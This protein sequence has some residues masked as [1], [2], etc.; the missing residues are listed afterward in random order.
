MKK[1]KT[2]NII[3]SFLVWLII[4]TPF[5]VVAFHVTPEKDNDWFVNFMISTQTCISLIFASNIASKVY[6]WLEDH[7]NKKDNV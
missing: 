6:C 4:M 2:I 5:I 1:N 3:I 7:V